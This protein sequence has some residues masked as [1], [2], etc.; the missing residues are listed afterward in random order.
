MRAMR[1][2]VTVS[3]TGLAKAIKAARKYYE[4]FAE[5]LT[6][7]TPEDEHLRAAVLAVAQYELD[8]VLQDF[9]WTLSNDRSLTYEVF[10]KALRKAMGEAT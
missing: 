10:E 1:A 5:D 6:E 3:E 7:G 4:G 2:H 8:S 9:E